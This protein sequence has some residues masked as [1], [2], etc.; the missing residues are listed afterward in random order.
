[1]D[2]GEFRTHVSLSRNN[3]DL[4]SYTNVVTSIVR[5]RNNVLSSAQHRNC[6]G[7]KVCSTCYCGT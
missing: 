5:Q 1:L 7:P 6:L 2:V 4:F 3:D